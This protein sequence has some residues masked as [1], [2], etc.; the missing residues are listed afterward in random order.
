MWEFDSTFWTYYLPRLSRNPF[1]VL[2]MTIKITALWNKWTLRWRTEVLGR[3]LSSNH[4]S[5]WRWPRVQTIGALFLVYEGLPWK[6][7]YFIFTTAL[8][9]EYDY[10]H[11]VAEESEAQ[12]GKCLAQ[13]CNI[14]NRWQNQDYNPDLVLRGTNSSSLKSL[15]KKNKRISATFR[16]MA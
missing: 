5:L 13:S 4:I 10:L 11:F 12:R 3:A 2:P 6:S 9:A 7:F 15:K 16:T 1:D 14:A 8:W